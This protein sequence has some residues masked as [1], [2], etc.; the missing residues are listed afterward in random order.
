M[1]G[2]KGT[3]YI[4]KL[5]AEMNISNELQEQLREVLTNDIVYVEL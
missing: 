5:Y 4:P 1:Y 2:K 3:D